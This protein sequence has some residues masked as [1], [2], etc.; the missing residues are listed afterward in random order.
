MAKKHTAKSTSLK[1]MVEQKMNKNED[2]IQT[3]ADSRVNCI[4]ITP[5]VLP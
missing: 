2:I 1:R 3:A 5:H 4:N